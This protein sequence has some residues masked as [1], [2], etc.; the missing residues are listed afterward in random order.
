MP[1]V[2]VAHD[3]G[4]RAQWPLIRKRHDVA[5]RTGRAFHAIRADADEI[6]KEFLGHEVPVHV[7]SHECS[8]AGSVL[9][10]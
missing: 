8:H 1:I 7:D 10:R 2:G 9:L 6:T 3:P 5:L 4:D